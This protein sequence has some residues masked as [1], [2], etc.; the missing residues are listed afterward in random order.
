MKK[1]GLAKHR[2]ENKVMKPRMMHMYRLRQKPSEA[3]IL[4]EEGKIYLIR[5][6]KAKLF[7][8]RLLLTILSVPPKV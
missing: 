8:I 6:Q 1:R 3:K 7:E 4:I 2:R 5:I